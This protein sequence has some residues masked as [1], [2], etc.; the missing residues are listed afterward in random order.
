MALPC[1]GGLRSPDPT[2]PH[3]AQTPERHAEYGMMWCHQLRPPLFVEISQK[4]PERLVRVTS[5][6]RN[7]STRALAVHVTRW[8]GYCRIVGTNMEIGFRYKDPTPI[9]VPVDMTHNGRHWQSRNGDI[10]A[11]DP[12]ASWIQWLLSHPHVPARGEFAVVSPDDD[13]LIAPFTLVVHHPSFTH[14]F[15]PA[16]EAAD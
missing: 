7:D 13:A 10:G 9:I 8:R 12:P 3:D 2:E 11:F 16:V 6:M 14:P 4:N 5:L 1:P 15:V